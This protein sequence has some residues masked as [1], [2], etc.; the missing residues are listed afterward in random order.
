MTSR[1]LCF[2]ALGFTLAQP[3]QAGPLEDLL[4]NPTIQSLLNRQGDLSAGAVKCRDATFRSRN[5]S[6]CQQ[7]DDAQR[8]ATMPVELR[9]LLSRPA[10]SN[11]IREL[12]MGVQG[13]PMQESY[14]CAELYRADPPFRQQA[15]QQR[16]NRAEQMRD[17][18]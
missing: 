16:A 13:L 10:T 5:A 8:L 3:V 15:E 6:L 18:P 2:L 12:C 7:T 4:A 14:L 1:F 9:A 11:S 17:K